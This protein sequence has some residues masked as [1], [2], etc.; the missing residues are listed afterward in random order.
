MPRRLIPLLI[1]L[2]SLGLPAVAQQDPNVALGFK[3]E[4]AFALG[5][6]D[7]INLFNGNLVV[8]LPL[9]QRFPAG[10]ALSYGLTL[11]YNSEVWT[12]WERF[13]PFPLPDG[14]WSQ[15]FPMSKKVTNLS[16][17]SR[18]IGYSSSKSEN[19]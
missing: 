13:D 15:V 4:T 19:A 2:A 9:G 7:N 16:P 1:L 14:R 10:G 8:T 3:P 6:V 17:A 18:R 5:D 12:V 11:V